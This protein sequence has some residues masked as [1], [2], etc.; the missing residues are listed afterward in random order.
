MDFFTFLLGCWVGCITGFFLAYIFAKHTRTSQSGSE[1]KAID[2]SGR[3]SA[4]TR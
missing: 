3:T 2:R 1:I 4:F